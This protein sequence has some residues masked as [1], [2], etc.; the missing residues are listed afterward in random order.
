MY[1]ELPDQT[2]NIAVA[3]FG[4]TTLTQQE[5]GA[6]TVEAETLSGELITL[7]TLFFFSGFTVNQ[8]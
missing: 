3:S 2:T 7:C 8:H 1:N 5:L 4:T 6:A